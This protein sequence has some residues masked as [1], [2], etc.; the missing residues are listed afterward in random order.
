MCENNIFYNVGFFSKIFRDK[1]TEEEPESQMIM[2]IT[3][4]TSPDAKGSNQQAEQHVISSRYVH[5]RNTSGMPNSMKESIKGSN[6]STKKMKK[7]LK[8]LVLD[9]KGSSDATMVGSVGSQP[10]IS[11][12]QGTNKNKFHLMESKNIALESSSNHSGFNKW[13]TESVQR[14]RHDTNSI[15]VVDYDLN[16]TSPGHETEQ[17]QSPNKRVDEAHNTDSEE[18]LNSLR[19]RQ[20]EQIEKDPRNT[21]RNQFLKQD[22]KYEEIIGL[23]KKN[24]MLE[25]KLREL[26]SELDEVDEFRMVLK[27]HENTLSLNKNLSDESYNERRVNFLKAQ[28][29]KQRRYI[30]KVNITLKLCKKFHRDL[31]SFLKVFQGL[32][33]KYENLS[34]LQASDMHIVKK[35]PKDEKILINDLDIEMKRNGLLKLLKRTMENPEDLVE[36]FILSYNEAY[37]K[38]AQEERKNEEF[39]SIFQITRNER[40]QRSKYF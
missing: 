39:K 1:G 7:S 28:I 27:D 36:K 18:S 32:S 9:V 10:F 30:G 22:S 20:I 11:V 37:E 21:N 19:E 35:E 8:L 33:E 26:Q 2:P 34:F 17:K 23:K 40:E 6:G 16:R 15:E 5:L 25:K 24:A 13:K 3:D 38:I 12:N 29:E 31:V 14:T 4:P